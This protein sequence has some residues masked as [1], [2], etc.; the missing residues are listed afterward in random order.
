MAPCGDPV[1]PVPAIA[2]TVSRS[3]VL[4]LIVALETFLPFLPSE[5]RRRVALASPLAV[6]ALFFL[7]PGLIAT[8]AA[9]LNPEPDDPSIT[10]RTETGTASP[11]CS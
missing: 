2:T 10:T 5:A 4:G 1:S 6:V 3:G 9:A 8:L 7:V 11:R